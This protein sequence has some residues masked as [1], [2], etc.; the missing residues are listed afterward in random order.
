MNDVKNEIQ[1]N[2]LKLNL[3]NRKIIKKSKK[4][5]FIMKDGIEYAVSSN[6]LDLFIK[7]ESK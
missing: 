1:D 7:Q 5:F 4:V 6:E 2:I 3:E